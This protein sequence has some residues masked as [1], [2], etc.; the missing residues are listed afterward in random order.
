MAIH[1]QKANKVGAQRRRGI[2]IGAGTTLPNGHYL[3][4]TQTHTCAV[5]S[6]RTRGQLT[7]LYGV[8]VYFL[9][10]QSR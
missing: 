4:Y 2:L 8:L 9:S 7:L 5:L 1:K 3:P 10:Q 6:T